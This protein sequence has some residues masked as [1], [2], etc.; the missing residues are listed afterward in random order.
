MTN[1]NLYAHTNY[2]LCQNMNMIN[3]ILNNPVESAG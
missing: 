2:K 3:H 1:T